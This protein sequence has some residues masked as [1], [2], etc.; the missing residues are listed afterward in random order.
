MCT[1]LVISPNGMHRYMYVCVL[2]RSRALNLNLQETKRKEA[3]WYYNPKRIFFQR[4]S[5][6]IFE[7]PDT[8][9]P[10]M[11]PICICL[12]M[13][14]LNHSPPRRPRTFFLSMATP[15]MRRDDSPSLSFPAVFSLRTSLS[16]SLS[17][18]F[19]SSP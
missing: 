19:S 3:K 7:T 18:S 2:A 13:I 9:L 15:L 5:S 17:L 10:L 6:S 1:M 16:L 8:C 4:L 11:T 12:I 14:V